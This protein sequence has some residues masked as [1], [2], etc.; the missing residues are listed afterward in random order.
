MESWGSR[1]F[2]ALISQEPLVPVLRV[3]SECCVLVK[4]LM[5]SKDKLIQWL[6]VRLLKIWKSD[7]SLKPLFRKE[8]KE[9]IHLKRQSLLCQ[10]QELCI[11]FGQRK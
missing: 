3:T 2:P 8:E 6:W 7:D 10:P 9:A 1:W 11:L 4:K 5:P